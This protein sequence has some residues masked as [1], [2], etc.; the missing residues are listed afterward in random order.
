M[1]NVH[2]LSTNHSSLTI[3]QM[4][5]TQLKKLLLLFIATALPSL[6]EILT[7]F[8]EF[9]MVINGNFLKSVTDVLE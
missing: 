3:E 4:Y 2:F 5:D 9:F 7:N 8:G 1:W 6:L